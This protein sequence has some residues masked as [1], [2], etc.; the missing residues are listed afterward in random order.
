MKDSAWGGAGA[1]GVYGL[2]TL[3]PLFVNPPS[4][5]PTANQWQNP[6]F[7][8][9]LGDALHLQV[10]SPLVDTGVDPRTLPGLDSTMVDQINQ[11]AMRD[12]AG[13]ARPQGLGFDYGAYER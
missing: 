6:P 1:S 4:V 2:L 9:A 13:V 10:G 7:P 12:I 5:D 11:F 8:T 3:D